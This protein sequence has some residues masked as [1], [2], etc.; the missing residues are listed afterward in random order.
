MNSLHPANDIRL[1]LAPGASAALAVLYEDDA[2]LALDKPSGLM[3]APDTYDKEKPNLMSGVRRALDTDAP[4]VRERG[5]T[6]LANAHR[7]DADT[8]GVLLLAKTREAL[9][10]LAG[11]FNDRTVGKS[12][13]ALVEG[14]PAED[15]FVVELKIGPHPARPWLQTER[16]HG[17]KL[18]LTRFRVLERFRLPFLRGQHADSSLGSVTLVQCEPETGRTHQIRVH[19]RHAGHPILADAL[20]GLGAQSAL[21]LSQLKPG[22]KPHA[23]EVERPLIGRL[24]LHAERLTVAHP[25]TGEPLELVAPLPK[26]FEVALK[27]LR[28]F[29]G[30]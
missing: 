24:A 5:L 30:R 2:L 25:V 12:Y 4:W 13:L 29:A 15:E 6:F 8:S 11:Q 18:T 10:A 28:R 16:R 1:P 26:D 17:G 20:Y 22:Y 19:L 27:Y 3:I 9:R 14:V 7:L 21:L 23:D